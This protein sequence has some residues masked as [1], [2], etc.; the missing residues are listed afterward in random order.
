[1]DFGYIRQYFDDRKA[2]DEWPRHVDIL[3]YDGLKIEQRSYHLEDLLAAHCRRMEFSQYFFHIMEYSD[4][5]IYDEEWRT[6]MLG[7]HCVLYYFQL[8]LS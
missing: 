4:D 5:E 3:D 1:M 2:W 7:I 8:S 6:F